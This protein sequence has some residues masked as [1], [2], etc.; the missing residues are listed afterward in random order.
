MKRILLLLLALACSSG[1]YAWSV[2]DPM[3]RTHKLDLHLRAVTV[4][5]VATAV[6]S[7]TGIPFSY[8]ESVGSMMIGD[9]DVTLSDASPAAV[10]DAVFG[11][12]GKVRT[13]IHGGVV[14][15]Q[16]A[17]NQDAQKSQVQGPKPETGNNLSGI[18]TDASSLPL[19]GTFISVKG[20]GRGTM[21]DLD[22]NWTLSAAP[23]EILVFSLLSFKTV[24]VPVGQQ[25]HFTIVMEP[26]MEMLNEVVVVGYGIQKKVNLTGAVSAVD[27]KALTES[28]PVVNVS[29][30]LAGLAAG[31]AVTSA[32]NAPGDDNA[33]I[34]VRGQGTL[35]S[36]APLVII[37]GAEAGIN[38]V[39]PQDIE[40]ISILKDAA[41]AAIYGSRAAG[42]VILITTKSGKSGSMRISYYG[43]ASVQS[44]RKALTP[45]SDY[46]D[47]MLLINEGMANSGKAK[48]F[49]DEDIAA[50]RGDAGANPM[51]YPNRDWIDDTFR[52]AV[53]QNHVVTVSGGND[54]VQAYASVGY[55]N[56]PGVME[57]TGY[58]KLNARLNVNIDVKPWI[59]AGLQVSG[60][61]SDMEPGYSQIS[62]VFT[63]ASATT[64]SMILRSA[65]GR[66]GAP[67]NPNDD[68]QT[69]ANNPLKRL[70]SVQGSNTTNAFRPR[71]LLTVKP[72]KNLSITGSYTYDWWD[73]ERNSRPQFIDSWNFLT[74]TI[75]V[76]G[77][78]RSSIT[79]YD[80][81]G[82]RNFA[83]VVARYNADLDKL[84]VAFMAGA[85]QEK[86]TSKHFSVTRQDLMDLA[87]DVLDAAYGDA[88]GSGNRAEW[89]MRSYFGRVNLNWADRYLA[90]VNLRCDGSSRFAADHRWGWFPSASFAWRLDNEPYLKNILG[91][92]DLLKLRA[93]YGALGN[94]AVGNYDSQDLYT[95]NGG[96]YNYVL[97]DA[98]QVGMA[99]SSISNPNLTWEST[100]VFDTGIDFGL[101][102]GRLTG[103]VDYFHKRTVD[104]LINLPAPDVHGTASIPKVN[105]AT[106]SNR[107]IELSLG[108]KDSIGDF[109]YGINANISHIRNNVDKFKGTDKGGMSISGANLI[110]EGHSINSQYL[111][112]VD[113]LLQTDEDMEVVRKMYDDA[114]LGED[115]KPVNPFAAFYGSTGPQ[116]GDLLYKDIDGNGII[117]NEDKTIVSDGP[118]PKFIGGLSFDASWK[119]FDFS[120]LLQG[121][122]GIKVYW[123][124]Q[125]YNTPTV[126]WGYQLNREI[127]VG[128]WFEGRT[129]ATYP[130][131]LDVSD[132]R[133][134]QMSDFYLQDKSFLKL[135][136]V[137]L[138]YSLPKRV[139]E[140]LDAERVRVYVSMENFLT[141]TRYKGWDP[142]VNGMGYPTMRQ[143]VAGVNIT[144]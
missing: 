89:A 103:T 138:G 64:P 119:G 115:G 134:Q 4:A 22:G 29:Q 5:Q 76:Y 8:P 47:Y 1:I 11:K 12:F 117:D 116:K 37:D 14:V 33:T 56:N 108:W 77:K 100:Y 123:L 96:A 71:F 128:R 52:T 32:N 90:E 34:L 10:V 122:A 87:M 65:D 92:V 15:I 51:L 13:E 57:N 7:Q 106:V 83:D 109:Q 50:W 42:G 121:Q 59:S 112:V 110:W 93:S 63:Y 61:V 40:S 97:G 144:F 88:S 55:L 38:S 24:E 18:V 27:M 49:P 53:S 102:G 2:P 124:Q 120:L 48:P 127:A 75:A 58:T 31:V 142:E 44:I 80:G 143:I 81:K 86:Y 30:A 35:N 113:R 16:K 82:T 73:V 136:N 26:D 43:Y 39:N 98:V 132:Y 78:S 41:S 135:R 19:P 72:F 125:Q 85:S 74:N 141:L 9:V 66:Y 107:G 6:T 140:A 20:T 79:Y 36:A 67:N 54:R 70:N 45:V 104:I 126:R 131:L 69:A 118:N 3:N 68:I 133:N 62:T 130:R 28:R 114:P 105:S 25:T 21:T 94:N 23:S 60:N 17:P 46:A 101:L 95:S 99:Q 111:L 137:Q 84:N 91:K 129:D 139:R